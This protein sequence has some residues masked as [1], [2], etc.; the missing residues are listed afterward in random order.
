ML[1]AAGFKRPVVIFGPLADIARERLAC[2]HSDL[3]EI[4]GKRA[5]YAVTSYARSHLNLFIVGNEGIVSGQKS[6]RKGIIRL[7]TIKDII[8]KVTSDL[9]HV[10]TDH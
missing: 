10:Y 8:E 1:S 2:D 4:A 7:N 6:N 3:Y 5:N 9:I